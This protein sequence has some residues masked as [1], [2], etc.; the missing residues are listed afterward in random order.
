MKLYFENYNLRGYFQLD[1]CVALE[2]SIHLDV[3]MYAVLTVFMQTLY[4]S[5]NLTKLNFRML[6]FSQLFAVRFMRF[7]IFL[8]ICA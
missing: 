5:A 3:N 2:S 7:V 8:F 6:K 4:L 1:L